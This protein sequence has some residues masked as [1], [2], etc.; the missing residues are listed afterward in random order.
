MPQRE[1]LPSSSEAADYATAYGDGAK[2]ISISAPR[3]FVFLLTNMGAH[4]VGV[5]RL[6]VLCAPLGMAPADNTCLAN[7][8]SC[9]DAAVGST[10]WQPA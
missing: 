8:A 5:F 3:G 1:T 6:N 10:D 4:W 2:S 9:K 7:Y